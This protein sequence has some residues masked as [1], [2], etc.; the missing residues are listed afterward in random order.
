MPEDVALGFYRKAAIY[1]LLD[2]RYEC[3]QQLMGSELP[4]DC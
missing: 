3:I 4:E 1:W 2:E